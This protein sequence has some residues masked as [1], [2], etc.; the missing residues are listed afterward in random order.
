MAVQVEERSIREKRVWIVESHHHALLPWSVIRRELPCP[1]TLISLDHHPDYISAF[2]TAAC[3]DRYKPNDCAAQERIRASLVQQIN[4]N[5]EKTVEEAIEQLRHDEHIS[6]AI[7]AGIL[8]RAY[9]V[10]MLE[11]ACIREGRIHILPP[12]L[13]TW[14]DDDYIGHCDRVIEDEVLGHRLREAEAVATENGLGA[15]F[16]GP[17][18]LDIDLD[19]FHTIKSLAPESKSEFNNLVQRA[20]AITIAVEAGCCELLWVDSCPIDVGANLCRLYS[21]IESALQI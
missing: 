21:L 17:Y 9:V 3:G 16:D 8:D 1:L 12:L 14:N 4:F 5:D 2:A 19:L 10:Q 18:I 6:A 11:E 13:S 7:Q 15:P 20:N